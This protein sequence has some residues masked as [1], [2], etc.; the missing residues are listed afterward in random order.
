MDTTFRCPWTPHRGFQVKNY[1]D[2]AKARNFVRSLHTDLG[3][4]A[5]YSVMKKFPG[6]EK[7]VWK[8][9]FGSPGQIPE[10]LLPYIRGRWNIFMSVS[11]FSGQSRR[12]ADVLS[13]PA[14]WA[15]IDPPKQNES[16][17]PL[18]D[19]E[20]RDWQGPALVSLLRFDPKPSIIVASGRGFYGYW[21]FE[22]PVLL[23]QD[24]DGKLRSLLTQANRRLALRLGGDRGVTS[25]ER[26]LRLPGTMNWKEGA[27]TCD[28]IRQSEHRYQLN[29]LV[30]ALG[31]QGDVGTT[32]DDHAACNVTG[33][34]DGQQPPAPAGRVSTE[35]LRQLRS[36]FQQLVRKGAMASKK[37]RKPNGDIDR[38][39][40]D[41]GAINE[42]VRAGWSDSLIFSAY[43]MPKWRIGEKYREIAAESGLARADEYLKRTIRKARQSS[44]RTR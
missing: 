43:T 4:Q 39:A 23:D 40:A 19:D 8:N 31:D 17:Q 2:L 32:G 22:S 9:L 6:K 29:E 28:V 38:S 37:Y 13:V 41:L 26:V 30:A 7:P 35:E 27:G 36:S 24:D 1:Y 20:L 44:E 3:G 25:L 11:T 21:Q 42:M 14:L 33:A 34:Q 16:G 18:S 12:V 10:N 15:D 5:C